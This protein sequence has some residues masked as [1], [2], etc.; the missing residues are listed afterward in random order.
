[1]QRVQMLNPVVD[2]MLPGGQSMHVYLP[3][4]L[5]IFPAEHGGQAF[6]YQ[7]KFE[8]VPVA[9]GKQTEDDE[10]LQKPGPQSLQ[11]I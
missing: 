9:Q 10:G 4:T 8:A 1:M 11:L 7:F 2:A 5:V 6:A 3:T